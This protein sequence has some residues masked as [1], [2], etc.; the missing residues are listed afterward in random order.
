[1][2]EALI[3]IGVLFFI[4]YWGVGVILY[5]M[6][7]SFLY[8]PVRDIPYTPNDIGLDFE[9]VTFKTGDRLQLHGWFIPSPG[10]EFTILFCHAN[11]GNMMHQLDSINILYALGLNCFIFDYRG[12]GHSQGRPTEQGTYLDV[13][14]AYRW[15]TKKKKVLPENIILF[16]RSLGGSIAA[17]LAGKA[18]ARGLVIESAFTSYVDIGRKFYPY[19]PVRWFARFRYPTIDYIKKVDC[20]VMIIHSRTDEIIPFEFGLELYESANEPREFVEI[21]GGHNDGFLISSEVYRNAWTKWL[22]FLKESAQ[23]KEGIRA[24]GH[25][26]TRA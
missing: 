17:Y 12:Y 23:G 20:P 11:G 22:S 21:F 19:M 2:G 18:K 1:M 26:S 9:E 13:R 25:K 10:A 7:P 24:Q 14:A 3:S 6:Q 4:A 15:L 16:G 5:L 8:S